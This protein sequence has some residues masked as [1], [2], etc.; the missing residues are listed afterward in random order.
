M[1]S[2]RS[3]SHDWS[4]GAGSVGV[5]HKRGWVDSAKETKL[6]SFAASYQRFEVFPMLHD[7]L[8]RQRDDRFPALF[9]MFLEILENRIDIVVETSCVLVADLP[10]FFH[11]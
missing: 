2:T 1:S 10:N 9:L 8:R 6:T 5:G 4:L 3:Y 11:D 7:S